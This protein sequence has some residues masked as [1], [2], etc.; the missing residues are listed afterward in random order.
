MNPNCAITRSTL[1]L[2]HIFRSLGFGSR[3]Y[4]GSK[5]AELFQGNS[6]N[7]VLI[8]FPGRLGARNEEIG[9]CLKSFACRKALVF[10]GI[11][12]EAGDRRQ[13]ANDFRALQAV[14]NLVESTIA[15]SSAAAEQLRLRDF[16][17]VPIIPAI[18]DFEK[19]R[20]GP[21]AKEPY[22]D[23]SAKFRIVSPGA[24]R[25]TGRQHRL[26]DFVARYRRYR[27]APIEIV[28]L[29]NGPSELSYK[30]SIE[31][32]ISRH[33]LE[34]RVRFLNG[35]TDAESAG[36]FRAANVC[37][38]LGEATLPNTAL[39]DAMALDVPVL[40][41]DAHTGLQL[42][43]DTAIALSSS[44]PSVLIA[45]LDSLEDRRFKRQII[46]HQRAALDQFSI[47]CVKKCVEKWLEETGFVKNAFL[48]NP[49]HQIRAR[50]G[51]LVAAPASATV[52]PQRRYVLEGPFETSYSLASNNRQM[53]FA[54][55]QLEGCAGYIE[56]ADGTEGY[57]VDLSAADRLPDSIR[58]LVR[59]PNLT[60]ECI[61]TIRHLYPF[62]P[63]GML[64]D[65]RLFHFPWEETAISPDLADLMNLHLDG[66][67][68]A[69]TFV[70][71][72]LRNSGVHV[73][74]EIV[75]HG[76]DNAGATTSTRREKSSQELPADRPFTFLHISSG[77]ARKGIEELISA[78]CLAFTVG[79]AVRLVIKTFDHEQ[80]MVGPWINQIAKGVQSPAIQ[81]IPHELNPDEIAELYEDCD[82]VV[83]P[84]RGEAFNLPAAEAMAHGK[85]LIVT[86][87]G[88]HLDFCSDSNSMLV[89]FNFE[90][91]A[92]H[93]NVHN[94]M[95][96]RTSV[97]ALVKAMKTAFREARLQDSPTHLRALQA[98]R[99]VTG[100]Q[101]SAVVGK[102][103][104]F[105]QSLQNRSVMVRKIRLAWVSS[106][107]VLC[108]LA[109]YSES[110]LEHFDRSLFDI[111]IIGNDQPPIN[112]DPP[113]MVRLWTNSEG[114]LDRVKDYILAN[115]F[116]A[117]LINF[118]FGHMDIRR[119]AD[120]LS[121]LHSA[122]IDT[123]IVLHRT[124]D[125]P[126]GGSLREITDVLRKVT[127]L[128]VHTVG[129]VEQLRLFGLVE[130][131]LLI[132][133]AVADAHW[134]KRNVVRDALQLHK[135]YPVIGTFGFVTPHKGLRE[136]I[137]AFALV[138]RRY[139]KAL[140]LMLNADS[141]SADNQAEAEH[142]RSLIAD[143]E[144]QHHVHF[145]NEF[146]HREEMQFLLSASDL[147]AFAYQFSNES[148]S[149][150]IREALATGRPVGATP[151]RIFQDLS[152]LVHTFPGNTSRDI[153]D[154]LFEMLSEDFPK[155]QIAEKQR[156]WIHANSWSTQATRISNMIRGH[157]EDRIG[158]KIQAPPP[159]IYLDS[160]S[161]EIEP[162]STH[163]SLRQLVETAFLQES[164]HDFLTFAFQ[165]ATGRTPT[166]EEVSKFHFT[167]A[168]SNLD[169]W[170]I[171]NAILK[172]V[173]DLRT[174][175]Y[176]SEAAD[177]SKLLALPEECFVDEAYRV[178]LLRDP[179]ARERSHCTDAIES[180]TITKEDFL[181]GLLSSDEFRCL[182]RPFRLC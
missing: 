28:F 119:L 179:D 32:L 168:D 181:D 18:R 109:T 115:A 40:S 126:H 105:V 130:N 164:D 83:L 11:A 3:I 143:L 60:P 85:P 147:L 111:T 4:D 141:Q 165:Q 166:A 127:R 63:N 133:H 41:R 55:N 108:G 47:D 112:Q 116:D 23:R 158:A 8:H 154:G 96:V 99:D 106:F 66:I 146:L 182:D 144:I 107:N 177:R 169:R 70:K 150:A 58:A 74:V 5:E 80:N 180:G 10:H 113:G 27:N 171:I 67:I 6:S 175:A 29:E 87:Y 102:V 15:T 135:F 9:S 33:Q 1:V 114:P 95:W 78:Y 38:D 56:P 39:L 110:L 90:L 148:A 129:D 57:R 34:K 178:I 84:T 86:G 140:L 14:R 89:D 61:V 71:R 50:L 24:I 7:L 156:D 172:Q 97:P 19:L 161:S 59:A 31:D 174:S 82:A 145:V 21:H 151:L 131:V 128:I 13:N 36:N 81:I 25:T 93:L 17:P 157:L 124:I 136:L 163:L 51:G 103:D 68:V 138:L 73:P 35:L 167:T 77:L 117:S 159:D 88:G 30:S 98:R 65:V 125:H 134:L 69:S 149:G 160:T 22:Y 75:G 153:A 46:Q 94:S 122:A 121:A 62:R 155:T 48:A 37:V 142:C 92:S 44:A 64:G 26:V 12:T 120:V 49:F 132:P 137:L 176:T 45:A 170:K 104:A 79:D 76:L 20:N 162:V 173:P 139:P 123:Y 16:G 72:V 42:A 54:F 53:A 2:Q 101:W 118:H 152:D 91:S 100:F 52:A 43:G